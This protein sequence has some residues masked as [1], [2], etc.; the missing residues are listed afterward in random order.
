MS[1]GIY[2]NVNITFFNLQK[3]PLTCSAFTQ[4]YSCNVNK[5]I[6]FFLYNY[7]KV[8][9]IVIM[10]TLQGIATYQIQL[11]FYIIQEKY[12]SEN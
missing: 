7:I 12:C 10:Q 6:E 1:T 5:V 3:S 9:S 8:C 11:F 2:I 4:N